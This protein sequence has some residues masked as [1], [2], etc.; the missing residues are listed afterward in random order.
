MEPQKDCSSGRKPQESEKCPPVHTGVNKQLEES[1]GQKGHL[2]L[3]KEG[4][5]KHQGS[6]GLAPRWAWKLVVQ[7]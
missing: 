1:K 2:F 5:E 6:A 4:E 7:I 3:P